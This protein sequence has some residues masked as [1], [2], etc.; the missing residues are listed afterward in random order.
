MRKGADYDLCAVAA[1]LAELSRGFMYF[2]VVLYVRPS[3]PK[4]NEPEP[5][6]EFTAAVPVTVRVTVIPPDP[7]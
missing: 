4:G 6:R 1:T 3:R 5:E 2:D 7:L